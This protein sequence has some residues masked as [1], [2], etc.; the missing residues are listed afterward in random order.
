VS[1]EYTVRWFRD[2]DLPYFVR[3]LNV[4]LWDEYTEE[5]FNWKF[6]KDPY[7]LG[8]TPITVVEHNP[9]GKPVAFNSFLP[10]QIRCLDTVFTAVQGCDGFV[11]REHRR[12]GLFQMT[13]RFL[14]DEMKG[15]QPEILLGFNLIEAA[16]AAHKAGSEYTYDL[17]RY[18]IEGTQLRRLRQDKDLNLEPIRIEQYHQ[19]YEMWA[20]RNKLIHIHRSIPYLTWRIAE[21]PVR[22]YIVYKVTYAGEGKGYVVVD[23]ME[24][25]GGVTMTLADYNPGLLE[26]M[27][28]L[29]VSGLTD[30]HS[31]VT[32][33]ELNAK[34]GS[35]LSSMADKCSFGSTPLY[36][37]IMMALNNSCQ[38]GGSVYRDGVN[39]SNVNLWHVTNI[40]IF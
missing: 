4:Y 29:I 15:R 17:S 32:R 23:L 5:V 28:P 27:L 31:E 22:K 38:R 33:V 40:D 3:G 2:D 25:E 1:E 9:T 37:V 18:K 16:E 8:F 13:L 7:N 19:L 11:E 26:E 36:K 10:I 21:N 6:H 39:V 20:S 35:E 12:R 24:E 34:M 14:A 30:S